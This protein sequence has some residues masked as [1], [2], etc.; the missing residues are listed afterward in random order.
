M[1]RQREELEDNGKPRP[2]ERILTA[3][4]RAILAALGDGG[5]V[6]S[7]DDEAAAKYPLLWEWM[8][9]TAG[10]PDHIMQPAVLSIQLGPEGVLVTVTHR[11]LRRSCSASCKYMEDVF[12]ALQAVLASPTP[13]I[14]SWGKDEPKLRK[15]RQK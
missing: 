5:R 12:G 7:P 3:L 9:K 8:T 15:R 10:G 4:D 13:P 2:E 6:G 11:D 14:R 1:A